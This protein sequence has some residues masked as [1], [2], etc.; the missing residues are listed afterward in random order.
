MTF[1]GFG[2][3]RKPWSGLNEDFFRQFEGVGWK[4]KGEE[5]WR[6]GKVSKAV[7]GTQGEGDPLGSS[8]PAGGVLGLGTPDP[9]LLQFLRLSRRARTVVPS[10]LLTS[11]TRACHNTEVSTISSTCQHYGFWGMRFIRYRNPAL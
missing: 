2:P 10:L 9:S 11:P 7:G 5:S 8:L 1:V 6:D 4:G 3:A